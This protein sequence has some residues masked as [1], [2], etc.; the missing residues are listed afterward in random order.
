MTK[1]IYVASPYS[2]YDVNNKSAIL[3]ERFEEAVDYLAS[4]I[5]THKDKVFFSPIIHWHYVAL[6][7]DLPV[8]VDFW[9]K[10]NQ[11]YLDL[12][13]ELWVLAFMEGAYISKGVAREVQYFR[14]LG[15]PITYVE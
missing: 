2:T 6:K 15:K 5:T 8:D 13:D 10:Q 7:H 14:A 1:L 4:F 9:W 11:P 12:F 3:Q